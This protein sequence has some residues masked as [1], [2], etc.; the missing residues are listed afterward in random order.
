M[1]SLRQNKY[2]FRCTNNISQYSKLN[3]KVCLSIC[4]VENMA[5][6]GLAKLP[7]HS[8]LCQREK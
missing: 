2:T 4:N 7:E 8:P 6:M 3:I 5:L 1:C